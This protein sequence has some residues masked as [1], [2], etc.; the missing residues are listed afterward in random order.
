M[1][2]SA[3][4]NNLRPWLVGGVIAVVAVVGLKSASGEDT[5]R[6]DVLTPAADGVGT[7]TKVRIGGQDVGR[8]AEVTVEGN[9]AR[10]AL[11]LDPDSAPLHAG[12]TVNVRWSSVVGRR[13]V[14][15]LPG[16]QS[17]PALPEGKLL[18][19]DTERV[20]LDDIVKA[21]DEPTRAKVK[22]LV[23]QL[24]TT[25][26]RSDTDLN[27]TLAEAGPFVEGLGEILEG[28]GKDGDAISALV[29]NLHQVTQALSSRDADV[30]GTVRDLRAL[31]AVAVRQAGQVRTALDEVP[32]TLRSAEKFFGKVPGA[33]DETV[34]LLE[35]LQPA[36]AKLPSVARRLDP[37]LRDLRP[38]VAELRPTLNAA[39]ELLEQT[40]GLLSIATQTV[41]DLETALT[42]LQPAVSFLRPYTPEIVGFLTNWAS[43]FSAKN[44]AGHFGRALIPASVSSFNSNPGILP[45]FMF[46]AKE[47][48][49]GSLIEQP[50]TDA[51]GDGVR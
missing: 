47:P 38:V 33:V 17:N 22:K 15:V 5:Y 44:G 37:V 16:P 42:Q 36:I 26:N 29:T 35:D 9:Q 31:V 12:T 2:S 40:P 11:D 23:G 30:A 32:A 49:P 51:N 10:L 50:W 21:L 41:P 19:A 1:A 45:P 18:K 8:V 46:Q 20:E 14:D 27:T 34:P 3:V 6:L 43:L 25:L 39:D 24:D 13:Y 48:E 4:F 7:G 28:V